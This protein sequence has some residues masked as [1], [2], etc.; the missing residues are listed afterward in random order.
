MIIHDSF[1]LFSETA[2]INNCRCCI[3]FVYFHKVYNGYYII[4]YYIQITIVNLI[5]LS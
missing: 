2:D 4:G 3:S 1:K 5:I